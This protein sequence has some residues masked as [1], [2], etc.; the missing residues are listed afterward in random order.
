LKPRRFAPRRGRW[1]DGRWRCHR[2]APRFSQSGHLR[3]C[4]TPSI[5]TVRPA[6]VT[7]SSAFQPLHSS[8]SSPAF[9][10]KSICSM[11]GF[12]SFVSTAA[13]CR[14]RQSSQR[15]PRCSAGFPACGFRE[16]PRSQD[17]NQSKRPRCS[18][19]RPRPAIWPRD[20][21]RPGPAIARDA[22]HGQD[23]AIRREASPVAE[24]TA[25]GREA[26]PGQ[27]IS[28]VAVSTAIFRTLHF[29][30]ASFRRPEEWPTSL[31]V[32]HRKVLV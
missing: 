23:A 14:D 26:P 6:P 31:T 15:A 20:F 10:K 8:R 1:P 17:T 30:G 2:H 9:R 19:Y 4:L 24:D 18:A 29:A 28:A 32:A 5:R 22:S 25:I 13:N 21:V 12:Y 3:S 16:R 27:D 7:D 11:P